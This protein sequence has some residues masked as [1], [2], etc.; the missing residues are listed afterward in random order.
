MW[1]LSHHPP[2]GPNL[3]LLQNAL[4]QTHGAGRY[5][6]RGWAALVQ[7][8]VGSL[9]MRAIQEDVRA[10]LEH[11]QEAE[12]LTRENLIGLLPTA[13]APDGTPDPPQ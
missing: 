1:S 6:A 2:V 13:D 9:G 12:L 10:F 5:D 7:A 3:P 11:P 4:D 8:R